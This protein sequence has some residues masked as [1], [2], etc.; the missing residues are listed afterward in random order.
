MYGVLEVRLFAVNVVSNCITKSS[1]I[2]GHLVVL[3]GEGDI[4]WSALSYS[5]TFDAIMQGMI[6]LFR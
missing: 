2:H 6:L 4:V 5:L 3:V 1:I